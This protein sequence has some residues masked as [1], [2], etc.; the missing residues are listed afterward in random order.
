MASPQPWVPAPGE[1]PFQYERPAYR[2][3]DAEEGGVGTG[4]TNA[5]EEDLEK[6]VARFIAAVKAKLASDPAVETLTMESLPPHRKSQLS[7]AVTSK[8][9]AAKT[10]ELWA[11]LGVAALLTPL[12]RPHLAGIVEMP[13][14]EEA[15]A[16]EQLGGEGTRVQEEDLPAMEAFARKPAAEGVELRAGAGGS[17]GQTTEGEEVTVV[18][19]TGFTPETLGAFPAIPVTLPA[20]MAKRLRDGD[21]SEELPEYAKR[22]PAPAPT[23]GSPG[24]QQDAAKKEESLD[25]FSE[26][27]A[28]DFDLDETLL[29]K[30]KRLWGAAAP[31]A[32][33]DK[34]AVWLQDQCKEVYLYEEG[35]V[36][37]HA[38]C[39]AFTWKALA[40]TITHAPSAEE[41][42][43]KMVERAKATKTFA[44]YDQW[45]NAPDEIVWASQAE[46]NCL[47]SNLYTLSRLLTVTRNAEGKL[48]DVLIYR[49]ADEV[50]G[51]RTSLDERDEGDPQ[52]AD[53]TRQF[54]SYNVLP[55]TSALQLQIF[56]EW[57][58]VNNDPHHPESV[59]SEPLF[60][61]L[62]WA[63]DKEVQPNDFAPHQYYFWLNPIDF[64]MAAWV[65][66][67]IFDIPDAIA[68]TNALHDLPPRYA[69]RLAEYF[70]AKEGSAPA[71][72]FTRYVYRDW[73]AAYTNPREWP[74]MVIPAKACRSIPYYMVHGNNQ[75]PLSLV[76]LD[77]SRPVPFGT[78]SFVFRNYHVDS[79][80]KGQDPR[81]LFSVFDEA[82][83]IVRN[84]P[85]VVKG[86]VIKGYVGDERE[87][88]YWAR[89]QRPSSV[90]LPKQGLLLDN[91]ATMNPS[92]A[93]SYVLECLETDPLTFTAHDKWWEKSQEEKKRAQRTGK[94][95]VEERGTPVRTT[96][97][98]VIAPSN[99]GSARYKQVLATPDSSYDD[100]LWR[101]VNQL[102]GNLP[103][104]GPTGGVRNLTTLLQGAV[105]SPKDGLPS[106]VVN[107]PAIEQLCA[108]IPAV[109]AYEHKQAAN[110]LPILMGL[111]T[112]LRTASG[113]GG[114]EGGGGGGTPKDKKNSQKPGGNTPRGGGAG[115]RGGGRS[116][117]TPGK[118][119]RHEERQKDTRDPKRQ[120]TDR[121]TQPVDEE[122]RNRRER[123]PS[124]RRST[125]SRRS[126]SPPR[127]H[128]S[129]GRSDR[130][131]SRQRGR[132]ATPRSRRDDYNLR[133]RSPRR[134]S[135]YPRRDER[136]SRAD[137]RAPRQSERT[138]RADRRDPDYRRD[139]NRPRH[140][141]SRVSEPRSP[142]RDA[143][144]KSEIHLPDPVPAAQDW[145]PTEPPQN[146]PLQPVEPAP[147]PDEPM[148][149][150]EDEE[151]EYDPF[152]TG[153]D[154]VP[155]ATEPA[156]AESTS[157]PRHTSDAGSEPLTP[158][159]VTLPLEAAN[160]NNTPTT[161]TVGESVTP[162]APVVPAAPVKPKHDPDLPITIH[163][164]STGSLVRDPTIPPGNLIRDESVP[165][166]SAVTH[167]I[168]RAPVQEAETTEP[169]PKDGTNHE[170][171]PEAPAPEDKPLKKKKKVKDPD[172][173][174]KK[175][176]QRRAARAAEEK[177]T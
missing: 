87:P 128:H 138:L 93:L 63:P 14:E 1:N 151:P 34:Q 170:S 98:R 160:A 133:H 104:P 54:K 143:R 83:A 92:Q 96:P 5:K 165:P 74:P 38:T 81:T 172:A 44:A 110:L 144:R 99:T 12:T 48:M 39:D 137:D 80:A 52:P 162:A 145:A 7:W 95:K 173:K 161:P 15:A 3:T 157:P 107:H 66:R 123:S 21:L 58:R 9:L 65:C 76:A 6:R 84:Q 164:I 89:T 156:P 136:D 33:T 85:I 31:E 36:K 147:E 111:L 49:P 2:P 78:W 71:P 28:E 105:S 122:R 82:M 112:N 72:G 91:P 167:D 27:F 51:W 18:E 126:R 17:E 69:F 19:S 25:I 53:D 29:K 10:R 57:Q 131:T 171:E 90:A 60:C 37:K 86:A 140:Q 150:E 177:E 125:H 153:A 108:L 75:Q 20:D 154:S 166:V 106:P 152:Y 45:L 55:V 50:E 121:P 141:E 41:F 129:S 118:D 77:A 46:P 116:E 135:Y 56:P 113:P 61:Q 16:E 42:G 43:A 169:A 168:D 23:P 24:P 132:S 155:V 88:M 26:S 68:T 8:T 67:A 139:D 103:A 22:H 4:L 159:T 119:S 102:V 174:K 175:K 13:R 115:G 100:N 120:R 30:G 94:G 117:K 163:V 134:A 158:L 114:E 11:S 32:I 70:P 101:A 142:S 35:G 97:P 124:P 127:R 64:Q 62:R 176:D 149:Y 59:E 47:G 73:L 79:F 40:R 146:E 130:E 148:V 109:A